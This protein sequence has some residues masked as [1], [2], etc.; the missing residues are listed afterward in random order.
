[1]NRRERR[2]QG[3]KITPE[4]VPFTL[5]LDHREEKTAED[6][7][8]YVRV[9]FRVIAPNGKPLAEREGDGDEVPVLIASVPQKVR[10]QS[11]FVPKRAL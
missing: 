1:M 7:G 4:T 6:G 5:A 11:I 10:R 8:V 9:W 2:A 3:V